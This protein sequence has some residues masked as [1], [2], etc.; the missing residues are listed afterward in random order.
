MTDSTTINEQPLPE[1]STLIDQGRPAD[2][3]LAGHKEEPQ[4]EQP[5]EAKPAKPETR[6]ETIKRAHAELEKANKPAEEAKPDGDKTEPTAEEGDKADPDAKADKSAAPEKD[7]AGSA[8]DKTA[9]EERQSEG[10]KYPEPPARFLPKAKELWRNAPLVVQQEV[11][12]LTKEHEAEVSQHREASERYALV[13]EYDDLARQNGRQGVHESLAEVAKLERLMQSNPLAG[14]N[15][16]LMQAGPRKADGQPISLYELAQYVVQQG[17]QGYQNLMA[18]ANRTQQQAQPQA[19]QEVEALK[20]QLSDIQQQMVATQIIEPFAREH[21]R[22]HELSDHIAKFLN[23]G[24]IPSTLS[25]AQRLEAAYD[26]AERINPSS[27]APSRQEPQSDPDL[28]ASSR[29]DTDLNGKKSVKGAPSSGV[30]ITTR[31][32]GKMSR[33]EAIDAAWSELGLS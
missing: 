33:N 1:T 26:M 9:K 12:R 30:D 3:S 15:Q 14:V 31:K 10:R 16:I 5:T 6:L 8:Q 21:P 11:E 23:S 24:M 25:P 13:K 32:R 2:P 19:N 4:V 29:V 27:H 20:Q 22:Y 28:E 18:Q 17:P 7:D